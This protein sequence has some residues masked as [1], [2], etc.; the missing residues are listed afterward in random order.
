VLVDVGGTLWSQPVLNPVDRDG[1]EWESRLVSV[2]V[3]EDR[4][5]DLCKELNRVIGRSV[6]SHY[7][8]V[9]QAVDEAAERADVTGI[10]ADR[11]RS[12]SCLPARDFALLLPGARALLTLL[13]ARRARVVIA[14]NA[15]WRTEA[16]YWADFRSFSLDGLIDA[17]VSSVDIRWR[18]PSKEFFDI[19]LQRAGV[20]SEACLMIGN[21]ESLDIAPAKALG[22]STI[23][24]AVEEPLPS[25]SRADRVFGSLEELSSTGLNLNH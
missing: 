20:P 8:D 6:G 3:P 9:W 5:A 17:V 24:V 10:E 16:D 21:S 7:F 25:Y 1:T 15:I 11:I 13:K 12:A 22:M 23:R 4:V 19:T 14:S 18:K 2:G